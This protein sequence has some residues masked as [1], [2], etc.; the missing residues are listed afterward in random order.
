[1]ECVVCIT[2]IVIVIVNVII[3]VI[4]A[5]IVLMPLKPICDVLCMMEFCVKLNPTP[6]AQGLP[7]LLEKLCSATIYP[8]PITLPLA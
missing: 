1:L 6:V 4:N 3:V 2:F 8:Q 7:L 5:L